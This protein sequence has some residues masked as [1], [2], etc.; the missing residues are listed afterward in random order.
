MRRGL[1]MCDG[2]D[3]LLQ[4]FREW[5]WTTKRIFDEPTSEAHIGFVTTLTGFRGLET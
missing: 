4:P 3:Q 5:A 2:F 1:T